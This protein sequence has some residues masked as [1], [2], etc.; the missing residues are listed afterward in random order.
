MLPTKMDGGWPV[1]SPDQRGWWAVSIP[2]HHPLQLANQRSALTAAAET[3]DDLQLLTDIFGE[4]SASLLGC[5]T[6]SVFLCLRFTADSHCKIVKDFV[7]ISLMQSQI[8]AWRS[9]GICSSVSTFPRV[10]CQ[11]EEISS[12]RD[13]TIV[14]MRPDASSMGQWREAIRL[15]FP[16]QPGSAL[17]PQ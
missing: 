11:C 16:P 5:A 9:N 8:K 4:H 10:H 12:R 17:G 2:L 6:A 7:I 3:S 13:S 14:P 1:C 15:P